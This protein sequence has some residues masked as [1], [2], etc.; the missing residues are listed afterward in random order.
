MKQEEEINILGIKLIQDAINKPFNP[1][2][3]VRKLESKLR[4]D[5]TEIRVE[6]VHDVNET[7]VFWRVHIYIDRQIKILESDVNPQFIRYKSRYL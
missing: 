1:N 6:E 4:D 3:K 2:K 7:K 5:I